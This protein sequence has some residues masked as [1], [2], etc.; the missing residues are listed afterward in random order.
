M[1]KTLEDQRIR[2]EG[3]KLYAFNALVSTSLSPI[4]D[5]PDTRNKL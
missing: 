4:R 1:V 2:D 3:Y 5:I